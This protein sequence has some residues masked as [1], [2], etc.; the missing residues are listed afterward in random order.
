MVPRSA[1]PLPARPRSAPVATL[2]AG[3]S[4]A[5]S[6]SGSVWSEEPLRMPRTE[7]RGLTLP[8]AELE[9]QFWLSASLV[10]VLALATLAALRGAVGI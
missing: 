3:P 8:R 4:P 9:R 6:L 1:R 10:G 2:S 7:T 5:A